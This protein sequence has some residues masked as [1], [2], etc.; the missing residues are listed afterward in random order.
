MNNDFLYY[1]IF[2]SF[3]KLITVPDYGGDDDDNLL[4]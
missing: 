2:Q 1:L 4:V 3:C